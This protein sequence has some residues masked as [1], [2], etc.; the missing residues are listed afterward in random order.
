MNT[1]DQ[2]YDRGDYEQQERSNREAEYQKTQ[3]QMFLDGVPATLHYTSDVPPYEG[4]YNR[5]AEFFLY[6]DPYG[7]EGI[8][9]FFVDVVTVNKGK[10]EILVVLGST[11]LIGEVRLTNEEKVI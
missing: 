6:N 9:G 1:E 4:R 7:L 10:R 5:A 3:R 2:E 11:K 8:N